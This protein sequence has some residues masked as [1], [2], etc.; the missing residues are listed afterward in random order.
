MVKRQE[1]R[2]K[3]NDILKAFEGICGKACLLIQ[4]VI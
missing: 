4:A 2:F 3:R 1:E